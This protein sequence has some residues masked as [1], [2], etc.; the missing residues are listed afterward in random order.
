MISKGLKRSPK[1]SFWTIRKLSIPS[2][3]RKS[4][5][6]RWNGVATLLMASS[7]SCVF[8]GSIL[9]FLNSHQYPFVGL[10]RDADWTSWKAF[11]TL[12]NA[13]DN[14]NYFLYFSEILFSGIY[15]QKYCFSIDW[16]RDS[17][18]TRISY[19]LFRFL[20]CLRFLRFLRFRNVLKVSE[21]L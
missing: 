10:Y 11:R 12:S 1:T 2:L 5:R 17:L 21:G 18:V 6:S 8:F 9:W 14:L 20:N 15:F 13:V 16:V 7:S 19:G 4:T 3:R